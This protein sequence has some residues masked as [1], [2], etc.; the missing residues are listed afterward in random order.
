M[1]RR[2]LL[3][4]VCVATL[5]IATVEAR[6]WTDASGRY[7]VEADLI[8]HSETEVVLQR[9]DGHLVAVPLAQLSEADEQYVKS[10]EAA[11]AIRSADGHQT[12]TTRKGLKVEGRVVG[13]GRRDVAIQRRRGRIYVNDRLFDNLPEIYQKMIPRIVEHFEGVEFQTDRDF[14]QWVNQ[15]LG[16]PRTYSLEGVRLELAN[17]DEYAVPF[18]FFSD[19]DLRVL[20]AGWDEWVA[21]ENERAQQEQHNFY[22]ESQARAYQRDQ[23]VNREIARMQLDLLAFNAGLVDL[24]EVYLMPGRGGIGFPISVIVPARNSLQAT[25]AALERNP[26]YVAGPV[27]KVAGR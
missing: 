21:A 26:G 14:Q 8:A 22:L 7:R 2:S 6:E 18:F 25:M 19:D 4:A 27:R 10:K 24:W 11:E 5:S 17:G 16:Q 12:W 23:Q 15:L 20:K 9:S 13:Y 1:L 3:S